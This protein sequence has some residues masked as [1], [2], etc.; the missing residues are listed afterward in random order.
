V[1]SG[2]MI[3]KLSLII[4]HAA[5]LLKKSSTRHEIGKICPNLETFSLAH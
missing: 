5:A 2:A 4:F 3:F 1:L